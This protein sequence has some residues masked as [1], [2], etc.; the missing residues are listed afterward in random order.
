MLENPQVRL[1][2]SN[3]YK[4]GTV[5]YHM[6]RDIRAHDN[7]ALLYAQKL[8]HSQQANLV[9]VYTVWNYEWLGGTQRFYDWVIPSLKEVEATLHAHNIPLI[10]HVEHRRTPTYTYMET[11]PDIGA[12]VIDQIPLS[13][14]SRWKSVFQ[15][16]YSTTPLYEVD[17]H[18]IVPVW[19]ASSKQE[20]AA[21]TFRRKLH[22]KI[23]L[24]VEDYPTLHKQTT[25]LQHTPVD[26]E[27]IEANLVCRKDVSGVGSYTPGEQAAHIQLKEF[28]KSK[29]SSYEESRNAIDKD[30]QSNLSPYISHG[31]IS[32]R[33]IV[34][35]LCKYLKPDQHPSQTIREI[36]SADHNGSN[37]A[38]G[39]AASF[40]EECVIRAEVAENFC[41]YN[42]DY[43]IYEGFPSWAKETLTKARN[44]KRE[45]LYTRAEFEGAKTHDDIWNA[46]QM[47]MVTSGKMHGYLR[48]YWAKKILEWSAS[49]E[50]AMKTAVYL[51][52]T[53]ELD[54]RDS[55]GYVG[56]AWSIGGVHDRP[57][58]GRP[59]FGVIR[60]MARSGV[61]KRG[62][63][64]TYI[65]T[66]LSDKHTS[67]D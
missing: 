51:N 66:W 18:N 28:F 1:L 36:I 5:V 7:D 65:R 42:P 48:M 41:F 21:H 34:L 17:A 53:Y 58:F 4:E 32:R 56:C 63:I 64:D 60:F 45:Y 57:W 25:S 46:A 52:D 40:V 6:C 44:D 30:G 43:A 62:K 49:P 35:D 33:R 9:V 8:A 20:F 59:V 13:F 47:Q 39:S 31:N 16:K 22:E 50:E 23:A 37:G 12:V 61:E 26:W 19:E 15:K 29:L 11:L 2:S 38:R 24:F 3:S 14:M 54:G 10:V 55:N 67:H 27:V